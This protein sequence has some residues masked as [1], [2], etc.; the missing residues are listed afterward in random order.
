[1]GVVLKGDLAN[2][3]YACFTNIECTATPTLRPNGE[4]T[5]S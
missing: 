1:M 5:G 3:P 4:D 2:M